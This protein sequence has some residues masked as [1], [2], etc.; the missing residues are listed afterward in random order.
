MN[1]GRIGGF[2][3]CFN[4]CLTVFLPLGRRLAARNSAAFD[5]RNRCARYSESAAMSDVHAPWAAKTRKGPPNS[6]SLPRN[7]EIWLLPYL[8]DKV[9]KSL[10]PAKPR[11]AWVTITDH[12]EP[13]GKQGTVEGALRRVAQWQEKWPKVADNAPGMQLVNALSTLF[14]TRK[15]NT[16]VVLSMALQ[17]WCALELAMSR[18]IY[19][20]RMSS[21][22]PLSK[23]SLI[24]AVA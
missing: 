18:C 23:R 8:K 11:R 24:S 1:N 16:T 5:R 13:I 17:R 15:R 12:Y 7:A 10:R 20:T 2:S 6:M 14:S 19:I 3:R 9:R 4:W 22:I 21:V